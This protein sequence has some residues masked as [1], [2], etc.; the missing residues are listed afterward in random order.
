MRAARCRFKSSNPGFTLVELL[1]GVL[2][3][4]L[5]IESVAQ[6]AVQQINLANRVYG[7][8]STN[9]N[10]RRLSDLLSIEVKEACVLSKGGSPFRITTLPDTPCKPLA[11]LG[12]EAKSLNTAS[13]F[14]DL[15]LLIPLQSSISSIIYDNPVRYYRNGTDLFR[16]GPQVGTDGSL[17]T[18]KVTGRRVFTNITTFT[19]TV[20][21]DCTS[22]DIRVGVTYPGKAEVLRTL[23]FY[24]GSSETIN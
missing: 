14:N 19:T 21:R 24:S 9:R 23:S 1:T 2:L 18:D 4:A 11:N 12:C 6:L 13:T 16:D 5:V 22:V 7:F 15:Y 8:S 17:T 20:A 3:S 10:F